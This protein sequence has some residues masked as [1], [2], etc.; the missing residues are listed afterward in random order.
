MQIHNRRSGLLHQVDRSRAF[1]HNY[2]AKDTQ[3][4]VASHHMQVWHPKSL[5]IRQRN[6]STTLN[7]EIFMLSSELK[8]IT[9]P[10]H[11]HNQKDQKPKD[12]IQQLTL[13][14]SSTLHRPPCLRSQTYS[15]Y[16]SIRLERH[17]DHSARSPVAHFD[18]LICSA[19]ATLPQKSDQLRLHRHSAGTPPRP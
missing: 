3:F 19:Q 16:I 9:R 18:E 14:S 7:L 11:T 17:Q 12:H 15:G 2:R 1:S 4:R 8:I 10:Q 13:T 6:S 5:G